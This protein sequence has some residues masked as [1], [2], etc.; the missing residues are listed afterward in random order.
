MTTLVRMSEKPNQNAGWLLNLWEDLGRLMRGCNDGL[1]DL[2]SRDWER[3][4]HWVSS[5]NR[6][7]VRKAPMNVHLKLKTVNEYASYWQSFICFCLRI[8]DENVEEIGGF[9]FTTE[10]WT[11]LEELRGIYV[12]D[13]DDDNTGLKRKYLLMASIRFIRQT[14]W[15]VGT[16]ALVFFSGLLGYRKDTGRWREPEHYTNI[17][18]GILWCMRVLVVEYILP[19]GR[20]DR[21]AENKQRTRLEHVKLVRD[22][23]LVEEKDCPFA[24]LH[25]LIVYG[26]ALAKE[27][28]AAATVSWSHDARYLCFK[29]RQIGMAEWKEFIK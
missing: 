24:T 16:P 11:V 14:V 26:L 2:V 5:A 12:L 13:G 22:E 23:C 19:M 29:G 10:Q 15:E 20:R 1:K 7:S 28:M 4:L 8:L 21:L 9:R 6:E 18:A 17:L 27:R 3:I 25:S